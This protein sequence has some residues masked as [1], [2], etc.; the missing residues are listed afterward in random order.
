MLIGIAKDQSWVPAIECCILA[1]CLSVCP[2]VCLSVSLHPVYNNTGPVSL[3][4]AAVNCPGSLLVNMFG[5]VEMPAPLGYRSALISEV[6]NRTNHSVPIVW[7]G[8]PDS[9]LAEELFYMGSNYE[10]QS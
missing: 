6:H 3:V 4:L 7:A 9:F 10:G 1:S 5:R 8:H 2:S